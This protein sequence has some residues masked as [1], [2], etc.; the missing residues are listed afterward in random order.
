[1]KQQLLLNEHFLNVCCKLKISKSLLFT[2]K[3]GLSK[4]FAIGKSQVSETTRQRNFLK[5]L[6]DMTIQ[7]FPKFAM[8]LLLDL[9]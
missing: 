3:S 5:C 6:S 9:L 1:V 8:A 7:D 2:N 4:L